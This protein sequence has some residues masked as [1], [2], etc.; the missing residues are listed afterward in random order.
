MKIT[1]PQLRKII[2]EALLA[3]G[4]FTYSIIEDELDGGPA[5]DV[6]GIPVSYDEMIESLE[7]QTLDFDDGE[8]PFVFNIEDF[9]GEPWN[10]IQNGIAGYYIELWAEMNGHTAKRT[11]AY[12]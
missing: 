11:G 10:L 3:E 7:G 8:G 2:K 1:R 12:Y 9:G 6:S 4:S 5:V